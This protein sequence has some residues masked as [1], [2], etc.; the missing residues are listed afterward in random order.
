[1]TLDWQYKVYA[2][3]HGGSR[4]R[5]GNEA[6]IPVGATWGHR[7]HNFLVVGAIAPIAPMESSP[8]MLWLPRSEDAKLI[9]RVI[10]FELTQRIR[11]LYI[12]ITDR[13][14]DRWMDG[15]TDGRLTIEMPH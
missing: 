14:A 1:M 6:K 2:D 10:S 4:Q 8:M 3:I 9:I 13:E 7:P 12:N 15:W 11:P 5:T